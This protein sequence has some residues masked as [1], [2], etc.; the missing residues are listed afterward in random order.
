VV[1][2][3]IFGKNSYLLGWWDGRVK[4]EE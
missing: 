3:T 4:L 1:L 2:R